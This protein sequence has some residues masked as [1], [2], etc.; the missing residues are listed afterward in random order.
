MELNKLARHVVRTTLVSSVR[1]RYQTTSRNA[2]S[3]SPALW[4]WNR[5]R[6]MSIPEI[7]HRTVRVARDTVQ[8]YTGIGTVSDVPAPDLRQ[9]SRA[10]VALDVRVEPANYV[11]AADVILTRRLPVFDREYVYADLPQWNRDPK[12]GRVA[13]ITFGKSIDYRDEEAVGDIKYLWEINRHLE[14]VVLAQAY[15]LTQEK[16]YLDELRRLLESWLDQCPYPLGLNWSSALE[17]GIRLINW[18]LIWQ[19]LQ[20]VE[21]P[22]FQR[23]SGIAFRDRWLTSIYQH[24]H[25][26]QGNFSRFSSANNHLIGEAAGLYIGAIVW[27]YWPETTRWRQYARRELARE[28]LRQNSPDGVN[29]EQAIAYQQFVLDFL[30]LAGLAGRANG[31]DFPV[32]YWQRIERMLEFIAS[33]MDVRGN[34][35]M[36][37]DADDGYVA[38]LAREA[39]SSMYRSLLATGASVFRRSDFKAKAGRF[40]DRS[41]WLLGEKGAAIYADLPAAPPVV[42]RAFPDGGYFVLGS[43]FETPQEIRIV[44]DAGPLGY[45]SIAAHGHADALAFTLSMAGHEFLVDPGTYAYHT[46]RWWRDYFRGTAAHN[47]VRI[48]AENQSVIG[49]SFLWTQHAR[50]SSPLWRTDETGDRLFAAHD[51]YARFEDPCHH[52]RELVFDRMS[53]TLSVSDLIRCIGNHRVEIFWHFAEDVKVVVDNEGTVLAEKHGHRLRIV[54][55]AGLML[56]PSLY[57]GDVS[58]PSGWISRRFDV[59]TPTTTVIWRADIAGTAQFQCN[60]ECT[61]AAKEGTS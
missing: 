26:V 7:A 5:L 45:Q 34:V 4:Y 52:E 24:M 58:L 49:G 23:N 21:S 2:S 51:G 47:T 17:V 42:R 29:R 22:M 50:V 37:G 27:P 11:A 53:R 48:D 25:Y 28:S 1:K 60:I 57:R 19:L 20:G 43:D 61:I 13:P 38:R 18:S 30:L 46:E 12:T 35:P 54:P 14:L 41:R 8:R 59:K 32:E 39:D 6:R 40:D 16:S 31:D 9:A 33:V 15:R 3:L 36:I 10:F 55:R 56:K 44:A